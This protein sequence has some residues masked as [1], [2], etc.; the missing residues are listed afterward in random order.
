MGTKRVT[1]K[2]NAASIQ[3][4]IRE[5]ARNSG[6]GE[7]MSTEAAKGMDPY[8]PYRDSTLSASVD[9]SRPFYVSYSTPYAAIVYQGK[10]M[11]IH[12][13]KHPKA[14][15]QWDKAWWKEHKGDFC[16]AVEAYIERM[17]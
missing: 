12:K 5:L 6:L 13:D 9:T 8:V 16:K 4:T 1:V 15:K 17:V 10:N 3:Q 11:T 2:V 14:S 7:F